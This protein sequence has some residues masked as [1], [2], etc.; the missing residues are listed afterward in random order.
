MQQKIGEIHTL[1]VHF[2][3]IFNPFRAKKSLFGQKFLVFPGFTE[4]S[5][6]TVDFPKKPP[7]QSISDILKNTPLAAAHAVSQFA[8][9][10]DIPMADWR[11]PTLK[12]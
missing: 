1:T 4:I 7:L 8:W 6:L 3:Q 9:L 12:L 10:S 11:P 2:P 5:T